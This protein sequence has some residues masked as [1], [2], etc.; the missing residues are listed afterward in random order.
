MLGPSLQTRNQTANMQWK[1]SNSPDPKK[2]KVVP[3]AGKVMA[4]VFWDA[5]DVVLIDYFQKGK[6]ILSLEEK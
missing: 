2:A 5:K 3:L 6:T 1:H 4:L